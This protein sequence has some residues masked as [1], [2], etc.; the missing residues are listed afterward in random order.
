MSGNNIG[1]VDAIE[2]V[3]VGQRK[4]LKLGGNVG[5]SYAAASIFSRGEL[6]PVARRIFYLKL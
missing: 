5:R 6:Q 2:L 3:T 1:T 4:G